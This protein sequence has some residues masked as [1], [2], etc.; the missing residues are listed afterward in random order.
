MKSFY[1]FLLLFFAASDCMDSKKA[2]QQNEPVNNSYQLQEVQNTTEN[3]MVT[4]RNQLTEPKTNCH[5][6]LPLSRNEAL[7]RFLLVD[8]GD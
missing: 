3:Q 8:F 5:Q 1:F 6:L 4:D 7:E 2:P